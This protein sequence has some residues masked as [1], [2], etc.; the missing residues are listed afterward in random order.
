MVKV[1]TLTLFLILGGVLWVFNHWNNIFCGFIIYVLYDVEVGSFYTYFLKTFN[2]KWVLKF[3]KGFFC[4]YWGY[5][6]V[7]IFQFVNMVYHIDWF[8]YIEE[9]LHPWDKPNLIMMCELFN[10]LLNSVC[11]NL[12]DKFCIYVHQW[13]WPIVFFFVRFLWFWYQGDGGLIEWV[14]KYSFIWNFLKSFRRIS[15][16]SSL[17]VW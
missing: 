8:T 3:V 13:Y 17:N 2:Q 6:M 7:F 11:Y 15:I 1:D 14:W 12:V 5:Y 10:V 16:N 9:S 4:V